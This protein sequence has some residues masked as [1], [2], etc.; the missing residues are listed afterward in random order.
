MAL[1][2]INRKKKYI[3]FKLP[4][5]KFMQRNLIPLFC[6]RLLMI[7]CDNCFN[8]PACSFIDKDILDIYVL[9]SMNGYFYYM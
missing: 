5:K 1:I 3:K 4:N 9:Y 6:L 2:I 7:V 8:M